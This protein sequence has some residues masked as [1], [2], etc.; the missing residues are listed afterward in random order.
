MASLLQSPINLAG[1]F[2]EGNRI[3]SAHSR[4]FLA[5]TVLFILPFA[6]LT[7]IST[8]LHSL[9]LLPSHSHL[10]TLTL[11]RVSDLTSLTFFFPLIS[12]LVALILSI[13]AV[14]SISFSVFHGFFGRPVKLANALRSLLH[15]FLPI[16]VTTLLSAVIQFVV[17]ALALIDFVSVVKGFELLGFGN[18]TIDFSSNCVLIAS[19]V[20]GCGLVS[21]LAFLHVNWA[22]ASVV[23]VVE[24]SWGIEPLRRS[25]KLVKGMRGVTLSVLLFFGFNIGFF[26]WLGAG[27]DQDL[28]DLSSSWV[29]GLGFMVR[30]V[31]VTASLTLFMFNYLAANTVLY[32]YAKALNGELAGEIAEEFVREYVSLPF[33]EEKVPHFVSVIPPA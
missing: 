26:V 27:Y 7:T 18:G 15:S 1:V 13:S 29:K 6:F 2:S 25:R 20:I 32:L 8:T 16:L 11:L 12:T 17:L 22:L 24:R 5:L 21:I 4:H 33:D 19:A 10:Q 28:G 23:V 30:T 9:L 14:G 31:A 3:I